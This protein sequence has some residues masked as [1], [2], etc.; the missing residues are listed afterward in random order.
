MPM[1]KDWW[2][3]QAKG[4]KKAEILV[5]EPIGDGW[6]GG[7]SAKRFAND[8]KALGDLDDITVRINSPGGV[9]WDGQAIYNTLKSHKATVNVSIDGIA[10]SMASVIAMAGDT[11]T[12][13]ENAMMMIH[14][15]LACVC[16]EAADMTKMAARLE[17]TK[18]TMIAVYQT[19]TGLSAEELSQMMD[20]ETWMTGKEAM[21]LGFADK[22]EKSVAMAASGDEAI[23]KNFK[24]V[25]SSLLKS[26]Q[27][28]AMEAV[29]RCIEPEPVGNA[30]KKETKAMSIT[31]DS[32]KNE[33]KEV[34]QALINEGIEK[35]KVEGRA[36]GVKAEAER[37][38]G[39]EA[40]FKGFEHHATL[41]AECK[42]D[43]KTTAEQAA[44]KILAAERDKLQATTK[45][46]KE[47]G[48]QAVA[49]SATNAHAEDDKADPT[50]ATGALTMEE[51]EKL[52]AS[53]ERV[54]KA[55]TSAKNFFNY[56][57]YS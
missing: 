29:E 24:N 6:Y 9:V 46:L 18:D 31:V 33:H 8:L 34:A 52:Y 1:T 55:F 11:I 25:P 53:D 43:G 41:L 51:A 4:N 3:M 14:N 57:K 45:N 26:M 47:D 39:L 5:Y 54:S 13:P 32:I 56:R 7:L 19:R 10:A 42:A 16:G 38:Q 37:I 17:K 20:A 35:G 28:G 22:V 49:S 12:M 23:F 15:P 50:K 36:E 48:S 44:V 30:D 2:S 21:D 40:A 27:V